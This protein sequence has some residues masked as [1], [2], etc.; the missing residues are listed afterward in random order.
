MHLALRTRD[1]VPT[2]ATIARTA[3]W[4][5]L[6]TA[7]QTRS[8]LRWW[9]EI[10]WTRTRT[11]VGIAIAA[12]MRHPEHVRAVAADH[13]RVHRRSGGGQASHHGS[14]AA[15]AHV[16]RVLHGAVVCGAVRCSAVQCG[17]VRCSAVQCG[18]VRCGAVRWCAVLP[19][20]WSCRRCC[21][22]CHRHTAVVCC[23]SIAG[24][25]KAVEGGADVWTPGYG[26]DA[27]GEGI[28]RGV[29]RRESFACTCA[30]LH[31]QSPCVDVST[32]LFTAALQAVATCCKTTF[33]NV[34]AST[35]TSKWRGESEKIVRWLRRLRPRRRCLTCRLHVS[36]VSAGSDS[37]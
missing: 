16:P 34:T 18:A 3:P 28:E 2:R 9:S 37:V 22:H 35:L 12:S 29:R 20:R 13:V 27:V 33:F 6:W 7:P 21:R 17:A 24:H 11:C 26:Q 4:C 32:L 31:P 1:V 19:P 15:A 23:A 8:S 30:R 10:S 36:R 25:P 5:R 14:R